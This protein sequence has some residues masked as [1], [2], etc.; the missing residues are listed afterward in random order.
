MDNTFDENRPLYIKWEK[1]QMP[2]K[3]IALLTNQC[4]GYYENADSFICVNSYF[5]LLGYAVFS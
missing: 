1:N 2:K 5:V 4:L 3:A